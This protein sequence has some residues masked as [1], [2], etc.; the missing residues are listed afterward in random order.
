MAFCDAQGFVD[1]SNTFSRDGG[2]ANDGVERL[3]KRSVQ[4]ACLRQQNVGAVEVHLRKRKQLRAAFRGNDARRE[5]EAKQALPGK[6]GRRAKI[7]YKI[8][9]QAATDKMR[10][11]GIGGHDARLTLA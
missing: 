2:A 1:R 11:M 8:K 10:W 4:R 7:V 5:K 6:A 9:R 3:R